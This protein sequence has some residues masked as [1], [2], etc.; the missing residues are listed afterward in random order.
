MQ[1]SQSCP[2]E[3]PKRRVLLAVSGS[4]AAYKAVVL[5]RTLQKR[6]VEVRVLLTEN[7]TQFVGVATFRGFG[8]EPIASMWGHRGEVH[9]ELSEWAEAIVVAPATASLLSRAA[10]GLAD[11]VVLATLRCS[12]VPVFYVPAMH[13]RMWHHP[14]TQR[15]VHQL[16]ID[17][18]TFLGPVTGEVA[19]GDKGLGRML[20]PDAICEEVLQALTQAGPS[21]HVVITAGPTVEDL[22]PVRFISNR[23]SG[24][25]GYAIAEEALRRGAKVTL[26]TGPTA[27][28]PPRLATTVHVRSAEEMRRAV[29]AQWSSADTVI[30]AAA[31]ADYRP[32]SSQTQKVRKTQEHLELRLLRNPDILAELGEKRHAA[33]AK[34]PTLIGFALETEDI[35]QRG[36]LKLDRKKVDLIVANHASSLESETSEAALVSESD[37]EPLARISK[38]ELASKIVEWAFTR[39]NTPEGTS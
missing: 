4:I 7:A 16:R 38:R 26:I 17:G 2:A 30:M 20:E 39:H 6:N 25:M 31:V 14:A 32:E 22:D 28:T 13:P 3:Q 24:Q 35:L 21:M 37:F 8:V 18:A 11:D 27:L 36:K 33:S 10:I 5:L 15:A 1:T 9:V 12:D 23:S 34:R 29:C 19:S